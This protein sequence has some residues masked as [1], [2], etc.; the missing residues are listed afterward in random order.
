MFL[1]GLLLAE[2]VGQYAAFTGHQLNRF[3]LAPNV[4]QIHIHVLLSL[5]MVRLSGPD[6]VKGQVIIRGIAGRR[7]VIGAAAVSLGVPFAETL[8]RGGGEAQLGVAVVQHGMGRA[9]DLRL[10]NGILGGKCHVNAL[11]V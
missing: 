10:H 4:I 3:E 5:L 9:R 11:E 1:N 7:R 8:G 2:E 6:R